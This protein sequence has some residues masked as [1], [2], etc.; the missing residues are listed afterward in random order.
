MV[1][2]ST[3]NLTT[4]APITIRTGEWLYIYN[5]TGANQFYQA[6]ADVTAGTSVPLSNSS[7]HSNGTFSDATVQTATTFTG[8]F[9]TVPASDNNLPLR[10]DA[11][12]EW[13]KV[14][15]IN[16]AT[17]GVCELVADAHA[18]GAQLFRVL[19]GRMS[20]QA[21]P[22]L[23]HIKRWRQFVPAVSINIGV[24]DVNGLV[25]DNPSSMDPAQG[26]FRKLQWRRSSNAVGSSHSGNLILRDFTLARIIYAPGSGTQINEYHTCADS[27]GVCED[28]HWLLGGTYYPLKANGTTGPGID[29]IRPRF[30]EGYVLM[31]QPVY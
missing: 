5:S 13:V 23:E 10:I 8:D 30:N 12:G 14:G 26:G 18:S 9:A 4:K 29:R 24:P 15:K 31:K 17:M 1:N 27:P 22:P 19:M 25:G 20:M 11:S 2:G 21:L 28:N 6:L 7:G 16:N 3:A